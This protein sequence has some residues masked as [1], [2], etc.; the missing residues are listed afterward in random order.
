MKPMLRLLAITFVLLYSFGIANAYDGLLFKPLTANIFEPR[1]GAVYASQNDKLRL[2]IGTSIDLYDFKLSVKNETRLGT[3]FFTYTRL[4]SVGKFKFP[5]ETS[6]YFFGLNATTKGVIGEYN[7]SA[8]LRLAHI[9]SHLVDGYDKK[10]IFATQPFVYSR[11]FVDLAG[12]ITFGDFRPYIGNYYVFSVQPDDAN[13][14]IPYLGFDYRRDLTDWLALVAG[15]DFKLGG[16]DNIYTGISIAQI[17]LE[18][19]TSKNWGIM[20]SY[21]FYDG[22]SMHGMFYKEKDSYTGLGFQVIFY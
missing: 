7:Y 21:Y 10:S 13:P 3:D 1:V 12:T 22:K 14:M 18:L 17:G 19:L 8:R 11:E 16:A 15:Y 2:D 6:D 20:L 5:V 4:R 9:S